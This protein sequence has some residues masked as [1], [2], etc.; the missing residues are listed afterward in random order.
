MPK[1]FALVVDD[2]T[3]LSKLF[4]SILE[5]S[6]FETQV[7]NDGALVESVMSER[8]PD[9]VTLDL[10]MP[11]M[12]GLQVLQQIR[13]NPLFDMVRV[14]VITAGSQTPQAPD[15]NDMADLVLVKPVSFEQLRD[16][17]TRLL[18]PTS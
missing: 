14:I 4:A 16:F 5:L 10:Q 1:P 7:V 12:P 13:D 2:N 11:R 3:D 9:L 8:V 17:A 18:P 15:V 6:G